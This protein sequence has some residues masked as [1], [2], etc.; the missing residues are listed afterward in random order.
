MTQPVRTFGMAAALVAVASA[1]AVAQRTRG[2]MSVPR[3]VTAPPPSTTNHVPPPP[4]ST[5]GVMSVPRYDGPTGPTAHRRGDVPRITTYQGGG[6]YMRGRPLGSGNSSGRGY[7][8]GSSYGT[9]WSMSGGF[10]HRFEPS[11]SRRWRPGYTQYGVGCNVGCFRL[12][13]GAGTGRFF[14]SFVV[15]YPFAVPIVV[16]YF[17]YSA[18][19]AYVES[20]ADAYA[21]EPEPPRAASKLI[22]IGGGSGGGGDA[23]TVETLGDSVR[24]NWLGSSRPAREVTLFVADST[25]RPLA[26]RRASAAAPTATFEIATLSEPVAFAGVTVTFADGV[27]TTT[28]VPYRGQRR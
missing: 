27:T 25:Q 11:T 14:G 12:G 23:L 7:T 16:P 17:Y 5:R 8:A 19:T 26:T 28:T 18:T 9:G 2:T 24:L 3:V 1:S 6:G 10:G 13:L 22:V 21:A 20:A 4:P 15:G